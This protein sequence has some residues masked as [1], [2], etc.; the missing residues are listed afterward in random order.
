MGVRITQGWHSPAMMLEPSRNIISATGS[1]DTPETATTLHTWPSSSKTESPGVMSPKLVHPSGVGTTVSLASDTRY[2][3][4]WHGT[5]RGWVFRVSPDLWPHLRHSLSEPVV[6]FSF[7]VV[8]PSYARM[9]S[10]SLLSGRPLRRLAAPSGHPVQQA[11][12]RAAP[13]SPQGPPV[14]ILSVFLALTGTWP[15][16]AEGRAARR[17]AHHTRSVLLFQL[18]IDSFDLW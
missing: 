5:E 4:S 12:R 10:C 13:A 3:T 8:I 2:P 15:G 9:P 18:V 16:D 6:F 17:T 11:K 7:V 14:S 1:T